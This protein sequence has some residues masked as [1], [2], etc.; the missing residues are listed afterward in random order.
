MHKTSLNHGKKDAPHQQNRPGSF[1]E[2]VTTALLRLPRCLPGF[3]VPGLGHALGRL[4]Y[5]LHERS[6]LKGSLH[7][8]VMEMLEI[9][10]VEADRIVRANFIHM[11]LMAVETLRPPRGLKAWRRMFRIEGR[12]NLELALAEGKGVILLADHVGNTILL[13]RGLPLEVD[14]LYTILWRQADRIFARFIDA[15]RVEYGGG[16]IYSQDLSAV[17][18]VKEVVKILAEG[19]VVPIAGD[20]YELGRYQVP[21]FGKLTPMPA[22]PVYFAQKSGAPVVPIHTRREKRGHCVVFGPPFHPPA[23]LHAGL[24][25][26]SAEIERWIRSCPEQ[27]MWVMRRNTKSSPTNTGDNDGRS[28]GSHA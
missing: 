27:Y 24:K 11:G 10:H 1:R 3:A 4:G 13:N 14:R 19:G 28:G 8:L 12:E 26:C 18:G 16:L 20:N 6:R 2:T 17:R 9:S 15:L 25:I 21:F 22:G 23:D 7:K 5:F